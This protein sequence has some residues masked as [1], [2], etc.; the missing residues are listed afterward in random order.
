MYI[1]CIDIISLSGSCNGR[2]A[3]EHWT[4]TIG[5]KVDVVIVTSLQR[6]MSRGGSSSSA[7]YLRPLVHA[8]QQKLRTAGHLQYGLVGFAGQGV[9]AKEHIRTLNG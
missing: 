4:E 1:Y 7:S 8:I 5:R 2:K 9:Q 6:E 3:D